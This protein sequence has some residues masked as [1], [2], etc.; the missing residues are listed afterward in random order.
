MPTLKATLAVFLP[1]VL[2]GG[3]A[4][5]ASP[6]EAVKL[7]AILIGDVRDPA[8][9][10]SVEKDL[11]NME[12]TLRA[13]FA[14]HENK[15]D[16]IVLKEDDF[17]LKK[18]METIKNSKIN[19]DESIL[20]YFAGHGIYLPGEGHTLAMERQQGKEAPNVLLRTDLRHMLLEKRA[21]LAILLTDTCNSY[22]RGMEL[23][24]VPSAPEW[25]TMRCLFLLPRGL[26]DINSVTEGESA[27]GDKANG[28]FFTSTFTAVL[29][30]KF[31][32]L[33]VNKDKFLHWQE[34]APR[35]QIGAQGKYEQMRR[36]DLNDLTDAFIS[37][38]AEGAREKLSHYREQLRKQ[39]S[40]S[41]RIYSLPP[42]A[43]FGVTAL[44]NEGGGVKVLIVREFTPAALAGLKPGDVI[45]NV[46]G[47]PV[48]SAAQFQQIV[49]QALG[50]VPIEYQRGD[51]VRQAQIKIAPWPAPG[52]ES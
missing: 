29:R 45:R 42:L 50:E 5:G 8:I 30:E 31:S 23:R 4:F 51:D 38:Q 25:E 14:D 16:L 27:Y 13:G 28:G 6:D 20:V 10:K 3:D 18:V 17:A 12:A 11:K 22:P 34:L 26:V 36:E 21:R 1:F 52:Q 47:K 9:G 40:H 44:D 48:K 24:P 43:R 35:L 37:K 33:D 41:V 7:H 46:G 32:A 39:Q 15:L 49:E 2:I 19:G